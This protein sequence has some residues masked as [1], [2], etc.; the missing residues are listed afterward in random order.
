VELH[1]QEIILKERANELKIQKRFFDSENASKGKE[2]FILK[3][4]ES[5]FAVEMEDLFEI[6]ELLASTPLPCSPK[7][8]L[9]IVN[10]RGEIIPL[11]DIH[12]FLGINKSTQTSEF[13]II[14]L[15]ENNS[16]SSI[17]VDDVLE[18]FQYLE[19]TI[20]QIDTDD[21]LKS[22]ISGAI[23]WRGKSVPL[24]NL[25]NIMIKHKLLGEG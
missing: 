5:I 3:I 1:S 24:L 14:V 2:Y 20:H 19:K 8:L 25:K 23:N 7:H 15:S 13:K 11:Y 6:T 17:L 16:F 4:S 18:K 10:L 22:N 9:G 21:D 12:H